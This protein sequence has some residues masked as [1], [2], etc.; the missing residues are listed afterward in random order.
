M[1][2]SCVYI[3][4][5]ASFPAEF[6]KERFI[7]RAKKAHTCGECHR[8]IEVGESYLYTTGVWDNDFCVHKVCRDCKS[9]IDAF[10]C[11][12]YV[13]GHI[14]E[15]LEEHLREAEG[16]L[17][18]SKIAGLTPG[19]LSKVCKLTEEYWEERSFDSLR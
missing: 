4:M 16:N 19:A 2:C 10:F 18:E 14:W 5:D 6:Y 15:F 13:F 12:G 9:V 8:Q 3:P 17:P 7:K 1:E 11:S